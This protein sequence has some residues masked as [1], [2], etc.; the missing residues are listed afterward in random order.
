MQA[1]AADE[2]AKLQQEL[3][4]ARDAEVGRK[5]STCVCGHFPASKGSHGGGEGN[6]GDSFEYFMLRAVTMQHKYEPW[7]LSLFFCQFSSKPYP[8]LVTPWPGPRVARIRIIK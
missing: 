3:T 8:I 7:P 1:T 6:K 5:P 4:S 2:C